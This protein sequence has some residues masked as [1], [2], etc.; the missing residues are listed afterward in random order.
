[1]MAIEHLKALKALKLGSRIVEGRKISG[2]V[3]KAVLSALIW[4]IAKGEDETWKSL[5]TVAKQTELSRRQV[6][7]AV[8]S[9][10]EDGF[11]VRVGE[12][13]GK[14]NTY[15]VNL[16]HRDAGLPATLWQRPATLRQETRDTGTPNRKDGELKGKISH[17]SA[18]LEHCNHH[19][20]LPGSGAPWTCSR[21]NTKRIEEGGRLL[22]VSHAS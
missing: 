5:A 4:E 17:Q 9:L 6:Q 14:A 13:Q 1:M 12:V 7:S 18:N 2:A 20:L 19:W 10:E 3:R 11:L 8:R 16:R 21:C 22:E 15:Q